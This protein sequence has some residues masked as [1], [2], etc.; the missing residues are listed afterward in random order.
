MKR[1]TRIGLNHQRTLDYVF[2]ERILIMPR[3]WMGGKGIV[4]WN[5][6][7]NGV[8]LRKFLTAADFNLVIFLLGNGAKAITLSKKHDL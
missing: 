6:I 3:K 1:L 5:S 8:K 7:A 2:Q 4:L